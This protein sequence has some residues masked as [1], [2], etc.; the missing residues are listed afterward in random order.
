[1]K[2]LHKQKW[3]LK[4]VFNVL[5]KAELE[6]YNASNTC[7]IFVMLKSHNN[8]KKNIDNNAKALHTTEILCCSKSHN[9]KFWNLWPRK[10][11]Y[12]WN[13]FR[14]AKLWFPLSHILII[15]NNKLQWLAT[16][17]RVKLSLKHWDHNKDKQ[18]QI[19]GTVMANL[20]STC[21]SF[22]P[23]TTLR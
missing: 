4:S 18:S 9:H 7:K 5:K 22:Y 15:L 19:H 12:I 14:L 13:I 23:L 1:M 21:R 3:Y 8:H 10:S 16:R 6:K 20:W 17:L 2:Y 11:E